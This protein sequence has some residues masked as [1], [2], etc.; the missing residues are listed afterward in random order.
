MILTS[1]KSGWFNVRSATGLFLV[2][3]VVSINIHVLLLDK[4]SKDVKILIAP[5]TADSGQKYSDTSNF[6]YIIH[7]KQQFNFF[8]PAVNSCPI[9]ITT[10][11]TKTER[12]VVYSSNFETAFEACFF[13]KSP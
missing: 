3:C 4:Y 13:Y 7:I 9:S 12:Y 1:T 6:P 2:L 5:Q 10:L 11:S 8:Y